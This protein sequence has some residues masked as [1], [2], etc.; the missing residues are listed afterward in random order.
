MIIF[1]CYNGARCRKKV[2]DPKMPVAGKT[3]VGESPEKLNR[4]KG[5]NENM[6]RRFWAGLLS[7]VMLWSLLPVSALAAEEGTPKPVTSVTEENSP[8]YIPQVRQ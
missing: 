6:K 3:P 5:R 8:V 2:C 7:F 4:K 1:T